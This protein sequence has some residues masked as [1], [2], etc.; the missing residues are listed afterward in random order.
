MTRLPRSRDRS[1]SSLLSRRLTLSIE[2]SLPDIGAFQVQAAT[3]L[4]SATG[5]PS[6]TPAAL[7]LPLAASG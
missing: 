5:S 2:R 4:A 6:Q 1:G 7:R 3:V